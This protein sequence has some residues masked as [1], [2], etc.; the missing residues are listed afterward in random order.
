MVCIW[1]SRPPGAD[2]VVGREPAIQHPEETSSQ[3][4][5]LIICI[6]TCA[7]TIRNASRHTPRSAVPPPI[8][9]SCGM[10]HAD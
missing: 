6:A 10:L 5:A 2:R 7:H 8:G 9:F 1:G 4:A 3:H